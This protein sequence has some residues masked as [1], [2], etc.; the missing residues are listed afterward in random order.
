MSAP[1]KLVRSSRCSEPCDPHGQA[2][3]SRA[4]GLLDHRAGRY[5]ACEDDAVIARSGF[6]VD[7][8]TEAARQRLRRRVTGELLA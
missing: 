5:R 2:L 3:G 8:V 7:E 1:G 6:T 4:P